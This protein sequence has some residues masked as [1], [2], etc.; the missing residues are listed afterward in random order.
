MSDQ[1]QR[2]IEEILKDAEVDAPAP[3]R[4]KGLSF[5]R[6]VWLQIRQS[7]GGKAWSISPGRVILIA[8]SLI[9][10]WAILRP[11]IPGMAGYLAWTGLLLFIIGYGMIFVR[12]PKGPGRMWRGQPLDD[13][14]NNPIES[15]WDRLRRRL[16]K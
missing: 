9:L 16:K 12:P 1:Y 14:P 13:M 4:L 7:L 15:W 8:L 5:P 11:A 3:K 6:L 2:E 10:A